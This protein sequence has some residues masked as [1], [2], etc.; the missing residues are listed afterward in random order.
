MRKSIGYGAYDHFGEDASPEPKETL[1][2]G[3]DPIRFARGSLEI[4]A[5][6]GNEPAFKRYIFE[7]GMTPF[8]IALALTAGSGVIYLLYRLLG[9][10][11]P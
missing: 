9:K 4:K 8:G 11:L 3:S 2:T 6:G 1:Y 5:R 10:K 7:A